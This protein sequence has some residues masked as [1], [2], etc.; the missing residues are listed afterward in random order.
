MYLLHNGQQLDEYGANLAAANLPGRGHRATHNL[1][2]SILCAMMKLGGIYSVKEAANF[3]LDKI[4]EPYITRYV[5]HIS[6][7]PNA[8]RAPWSIV[9]DIH[10]HNFPAGKQT[11]NDSGASSTGEAIFEIKT[12]TACPSRYEHN[13]TTT[14]PPDRR[15]KEV[16]HEYRRKFKKLDTKFASNVVGDG[17]SDIVGPFEASQ[18]RFYRGQVIP[19]CAGWF[20]EINE[21]FDKIIFTLARE[22][23]SGEN[24]MSISPLINSDRKGGAFPIMLQQF[25]RAIGVCIVR[26]QAKLKLSRLHYVRETVAEAADICKQNHS[27]NKWNPNQ[28]GSSSWFSEN[29]PMGYGTFEQFRNGH[30]FCVP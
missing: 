9:P 28:N 15:A 6:S 17:D 25:R 13:N 27:D 14:C 30:D 26:G 5:N 21:D 3:L 24:G 1:L 20:G 4:G 11:I 22:A 12:Y 19:L 29:C 23:A 10:A 18:G 7:F 16:T 8:R 2:Q